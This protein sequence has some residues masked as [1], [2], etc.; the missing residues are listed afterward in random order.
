VTVTPRHH[1]R[2]AKGAREGRQQTP[3]K[4]IRKVLLQLY[5]K[6]HPRNALALQNKFAVSIESNKEWREL[7][8]ASIVPKAQ[9]LTYQ[10]DQTKNGADCILFI[11]GAPLFEVLEHRVIINSPSPS[12]SS[13]LLFIDSGMLN[14][15]LLLNRDSILSNIRLPKFEIQSINTAWH[16]EC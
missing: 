14:A 15:V 9:L 2:P 13:K 12:T 1:R 4:Q 3:P 6:L 8:F 16:N 5:Y 10:S 7:I 11:A